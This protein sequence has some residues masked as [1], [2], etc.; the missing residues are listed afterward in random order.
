MSHCERVLSASFFNSTQNL[1]SINFLI[2]TD[3]RADWNT[4]SGEMVINSLFSGN[5]SVQLSHNICNSHFNDTYNTKM[6]ILW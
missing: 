4:N 1:F 2:N 6:G 5:E 3:I